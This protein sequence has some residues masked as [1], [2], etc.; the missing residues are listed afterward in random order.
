MQ[1]KVIL[2]KKEKLRHSPGH[3]TSALTQEDFDTMQKQLH[4]EQK[5]NKNISGPTIFIEVEF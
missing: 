1:N 2:I 5:I 4:Q 3:E